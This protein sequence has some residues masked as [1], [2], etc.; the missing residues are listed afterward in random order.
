MLKKYRSWLPILIPILITI[1]IILT[2]RDALRAL[3]VVPVAFVIYIFR[4]ITSNIHQE[5]L[6]ITFVAI[7]S[8]IALLNLSLRRERPSQEVMDVNKYPSRLDFWIRS[9]QRNQRSRYFK[10]NLAQDLSYL[11]T[12]V[13]AFRQ[14]ISR[15]Q[16]LRRLEAGRLDLPPDIRAYL[17][18]SHKPFTRSRSTSQTDGSFLLRIWDALTNQLTD[19]SNQDE[20]PLDLDPERIV[21]YIEEYLELDPEVWE[22]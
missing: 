3:F 11:F 21:H 13:L 20:S 7:T 5:I 1:L 12:E 6:W 16:V 19:H 10:W 15:R 17:I 4:S 2:Y 14:G 18:E 9:V 22:G 8:I